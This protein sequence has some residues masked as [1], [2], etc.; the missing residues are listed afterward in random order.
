MNKW[1]KEEKMRKY[2]IEFKGKHIHDLENNICKLCGM[3]R[4]R[5]LYN[6]T[7]DKK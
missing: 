2:D 7:E 1:D 3:T 4:D 5:I 6:S